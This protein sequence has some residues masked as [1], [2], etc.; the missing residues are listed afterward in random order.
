M[1]VVTLSPAQFTRFASTHRYRNYYQTTSYGD[2]MVKFGYN[3]HYLGVINQNNKLIAASL[4]LYKEVFM[5][6]KIAYAP[7]GILCNY[8]DKKEL[9][10]IIDKLKKV[11]GKQGFMLLRIDPNIP[12][13]IRD[14]KGRIINFNNQASDIIKN[15]RRL[16]FSYKG[17]TKF[18]ETEKPR[19]EALVLLNRDSRDI[20]EHF[21]KRT[22]NKIRRAQNS[23][24]EVIKDK[25]NNIEELY[26]FIK[27]KQRNPIS[28]YKHLINNFKDNVEIYYTIINTNTFTVNSRRM[29]EQEQETNNELAE[30]IQRPYLDPK[31]RSNYLNQKMESDKLLET[32][33]NN[34]VLA[35]ELLKTHPNG[36]KIAG[37]LSITY[38]NAAYI[39][40]DGINEKYSSLNANY[41]VKW[42][43]IDD[44]NKR[45]FKYVNLNAIA[46]EFEEKT[47]YSGL[48]ESKLGFNSTV[49]EYI[50]EFE[51]II[52]SFAY[53]LYKNF[54]KGK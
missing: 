25:T 51:I 45:G 10:E 6:N 31:E 46:G 14:T 41:L 11:L 39:F 13:T 30:M 1:K 43:M 21:D 34:L 53:N 40:I 22:R 27:K 35:T 23:G 15:L 2:T 28:F 52:N 32:Y 5:S 18:F 26:D 44:Y 47:D 8:E 38:D 4:I 48:N 24:L 42:V 54:K 49:T 29:F 50:G 9:Q 36:L 12:E 19:W 20:F 17:K 37:A 7:R 16:G 3:V 33:K